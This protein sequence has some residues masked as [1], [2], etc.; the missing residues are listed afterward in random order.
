[1]V[2]GGPPDRPVHLG[3]VATVRDT[4]AEPQ[5]LARL[6]GMP[7]VQVM[8]LR[9]E[10]TNLIR[11]AKD[12]RAAI[13][14]LALELPADLDVEVILDESEAIRKEL[15]I[16]TQRA[17][18]SLVCIFVVLLL[19]QRRL[20]SALVV[21][22]SVLFSALGTF[23]LFRIAGLGIDLVTLSGLALA[24]GMAVDNSIVLLENIQL[25]ARNARNRVRVLAAAREVLFPLLAGALTTAV[26]MTPFLYLT[27]DLKD[28]Y[29][30]FVLAV[31]LSL[32]ASLFVAFTLTPLL[33]RW[34]ESTQRIRGPE[35]PP[36]VAQFLG[37]SWFGAGYGFLVRHT[38]AHPRITAGVSLLLLAGSIW[39]FQTQ[40]SRG[41]IFPY[42]PQT[43]LSVTLGLPPGAE[44]AQA[45]NMIRD[46]EDSVLRHPFREAGYI[47]QVRTMVRMNRAYLIVE[48]HPAV[49]RTSI[50]EVLKQE[51]ILLAATKA[52]AN[53]SVQGQGPGYNAGS[54][55]ISAS[56]SLRV[57]GPDY[58]TLAELAEDIGR[59]LER[60]GRIN[61]VNTNA[62]SWMAKDAIEFAAVPHREQMGELGVTM[63]SVSS[64]LQPVMGGEYA[65]RRLAS[66]EGEMLA[67]VRWGEGS[68]PTPEELLDAT[69]LAPSGAVYPFREVLSVEERRVQR[70]IHR[71]NQEY[72]RMISFEFRGPGR[73]GNRYLKAFLEGTRVP[74]GYTLEESQGVFL[75]SREEQQI[76]M[77]LLLALLLIYMVSAALFESL[78]LP[79]V[80]ILS[81]PLSFVGVALAFWLAD[82][83]FDRTAY[84]GLILLAGIAINNALLLVHRAGALHRKTRRVLESA[85]RAAVER[86]RPILLTTV[87]SV[88]GLAPLIWGVDPEGAASW[89]TLA[90]AATAGLLASAVFTLLVVP[91]L[92][93]L[94]VGRGRTPAAL[95]S[96]PLSAGDRG[97]S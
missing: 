26:V 60:H 39:V 41:S 55:S 89:R 30:P 11:V 43:V 63:A 10:G 8:V 78:V 38:L 2:V 15:N 31:T 86:L 42:R 73:V 46:F 94:F 18:L 56:Y 93:S 6:N 68:A 52:G 53:I 44:V 71:R 4:W 14:E 27:A 16:L 25:R 64:S 97:M 82:E 32:L 80:A 88:A 61:E 40:V 87:T 54:G 34:S 59:R 37:M 70:E 47:K 83:S 81:V 50:P 48:F 29:L 95:P 17:A 19:A 12:V 92:F 85:R 69:G 91:P 58:L 51:M 57:R 21:L 72:E 24:F 1:V 20:P 62:S 3:E 74:P 77:A 49:N 76:Y 22:T 75:T 84:I 33:A 36:R 45:D 5:G 79:F 96:G 13:D 35:L 9:E 90:I 7:S 28:Y 65:V 23:L 66:P 67:S